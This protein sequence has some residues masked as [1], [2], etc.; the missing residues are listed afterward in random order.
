VKQK[1]CDGARMRRLRKMVREEGGG[2]KGGSPC[3]KVKSG[4]IKEEDGV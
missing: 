1:C 2:E 3:S 4:G